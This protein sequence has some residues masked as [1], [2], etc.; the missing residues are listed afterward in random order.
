MFKKNDTVPLILALV[1]T[2]VV[3]GLGYGAWTKINS[4]ITVD[5]NASEESSLSV[6]PN[7]NSST[8]TSP[9]SF[10]APGI[11]PM[12]IS[13]RINGSSQMIKVN[14]LLKKSF[15]KEFPGTT[16]NVGADGNETSMRLLLSGQIDLAAIDRP[17]SEAE[18]AK[19][20][21]TVTLQGKHSQPGDGS[22]PQI[23][24]YAYHQ[25][26]NSKVEAFLG[27]LS[28]AQGQQSIVNR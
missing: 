25:P 21:T 3:V 13:V 22:K 10:S 14:Q 4:T 17:L 20:F 2:L 23:F 5:D 26:A 24:F 1:S 9:T 28:S 8:A 12:G 15:Q 27:H 16:V 6:E 19:G 7:S 11:L 18:K